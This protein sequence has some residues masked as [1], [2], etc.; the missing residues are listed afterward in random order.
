MV[1]RLKNFENRGINNA[2]VNSIRKIY[3]FCLDFVWCRDQML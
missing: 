2:R 3:R 1:E